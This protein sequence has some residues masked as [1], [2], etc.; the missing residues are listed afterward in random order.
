METTVIA[1]VIIIFT[2]HYGT[3]PRTVLC[4]N[5]SEALMYLPT[6]IPIQNPNVKGISM[7]DEES[8]IDK[9]R[10]SLSI[11]LSGYLICAAIDLAILVVYVALWGHHSCYGWSIMAVVISFL[12]WYACAATI[13]ATILSTRFT[14]F[15]TFGFNT[16][17]WASKSIR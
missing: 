5:P 10:T 6:E 7:D 9:Y 17:M 4:G 2:I 15:T 16:V 12:S 1:A 13:I 8:I 14:L 11:R 3:A